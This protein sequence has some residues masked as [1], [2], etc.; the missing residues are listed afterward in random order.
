MCIIFRLK[1]LQEQITLQ[2][3]VPG[4]NQLLLFNKALLISHVHPSAEIS[5][6]PTTSHS[7]PIILVHTE[8][9]D[10]K[11]LTRLSALS[12]CFPN[13]PLT[14]NLSDDAALAKTC[15]SVGH[16]VKRIIVKLARSREHLLKIPEVLL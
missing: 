15:C 10:V 6:Y 4:A 3:N 14:I 9:T 5:T 2:T 13:F 7:N 16:A 1:D 8:N 11:D 12:A